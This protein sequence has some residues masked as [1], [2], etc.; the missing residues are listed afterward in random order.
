VLY[1]VN[2]ATPT[3]EN[4]L[5]TNWCVT[6]FLLKECDFKGN[7]IMRQLNYNRLSTVWVAALT[8][9]TTGRM[10][11]TI[12]SLISSK[13]LSDIEI[14]CLTSCSHVDK[15]SKTICEIHVRKYYL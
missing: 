11:F 5:Q 6:T 14:L 8:S 9:A 7:V 13:D 1:D 10:Q 12:V 15:F 3:M 4:L 2:A